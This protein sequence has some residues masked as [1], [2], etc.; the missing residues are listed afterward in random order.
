M[1]RVKISEKREKNNTNRHQMCKKISEIDYC[2][3][4]VNF[5]IIRINAEE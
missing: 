1:I 4:F 3:C 2:T 5:D